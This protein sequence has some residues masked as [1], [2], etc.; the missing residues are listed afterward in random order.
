MI[1]QY[2]VPEKYAG[3]SMQEAMEK[4]RRNA[5]KDVFLSALFFKSF[6][7][8]QTDLSVRFNV[9]HLDLD[10]VPYLKMVVNVLNIIF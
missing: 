6:L 7:Y 5:G 10:V 9:H 2:D 8:R 4:F 3:M 1:T